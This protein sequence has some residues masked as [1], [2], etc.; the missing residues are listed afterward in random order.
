MLC[1]TAVIGSATATDVERVAFRS[2]YILIK[3]NIAFTELS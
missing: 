1:N 2:N 3:I